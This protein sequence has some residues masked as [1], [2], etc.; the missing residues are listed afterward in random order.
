MKKL[1]IY[2]FAIITCF[3]MGCKKDQQN[4]KIYLLKQQVTD[5]QI[6]GGPLDTTVYTYDGQNRITSIND[7]TPPYRTLSV[8]LTYDNNNRI[9]IA[10][11]Y[12]NNGGLIV[13]FDFFYTPGGSG[14]SFY[15]PTHIP[16]TAFFT[17]NDK[18]QVI[19]IQSKHSGTQIF[20]YDNKGNISTSEGF[21]ADGSTNLRD[22]VTYSYDDKKNPFSQ[23]PPNNYFFMF[24]AFIDNKDVSSLVNNVIVRNADIYTYTYNS[25]GFPIKGLATSATTSIP[26]Y[27]NYIVK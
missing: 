10:R 8:S 14:Y 22:K 3:I 5:Y 9:S 20:T 23:T 13:E 24:I 27:Y 11:K 2:S 19:K 6:I 7:G 1:F 4:N 12:N 17:F 18:K 25:L 26:I 15:G 21:A 16:D